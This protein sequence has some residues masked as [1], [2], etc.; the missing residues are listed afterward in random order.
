MASDPAGPASSS[1]EARAASDLPLRA[2]SGVVM[3][4]AALL[5]NWIGGIPFNL[6][7][8][9][10]A[11]VVLWEWV[12]LVSASPQRLVWIAA[13]VIYAAVLAASPILLRGD[14]RYGMLA[15]FF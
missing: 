15:I 6:F 12:R 14:A 8:I 4:G 10:A 7:W 3:A 2:S 1:R 13:G 5:L 11:L 9:A